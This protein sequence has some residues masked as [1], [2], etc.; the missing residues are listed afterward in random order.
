MRTWEG[1]GQP[2]VDVRLEKI[3]ATIFVKFTQINEIFCIFVW[4]VMPVYHIYFVVNPVFW[5]AIIEIVKQEHTCVYIQCE[6][7]TSCNVSDNANL[8]SARTRGGGWGGVVNQMWTGLDTGRG[9][10][11]FSNLC[12]HPLWMTPKGFRF[13]G[14]RF[15]G[16]YLAPDTI[17]ILR[18]TCRVTDR[19]LLFIHSFISKRIYIQVADYYAF[20]VFKQK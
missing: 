20:W 12:G 17:T 8:V 5:N 4:P 13:G 16:I 3:I 9:S 19:I 14:Y 11:K 7:F 15:F 10:Q 18:L 2:N 1:S 6:L